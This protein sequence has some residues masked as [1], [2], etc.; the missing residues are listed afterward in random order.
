MRLSEVLEMRPNIWDEENKFP[1]FDEIYRA[2]LQDKIVD[3]YRNYEI[4]QETIGMFCH[5]LNRKMRE[6][7]PYYNQLYKSQIDLDPLQTMSITTESESLA[8]ETTGQESTT[9]NTSATDSKSRSVSSET[10][11]TMLS[12][13]EDYASSAADAI[14]NT[15]VTGNA[16]GNVSGNTNS[17]GTVSSTVTGSQ[18]HAATLLMQ[19]RKSFLNLDMDVIRELESLFMMVWD[20]GDEFNTDSSFG[21]IYYGWPYG[22]F[23]TI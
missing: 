16:A 6:I 4:G 18:G 11:Q 1:I 7:M 21:G 2:T 14:S 15:N 22:W 3:H 17:N 9:T 13:N 20:N 19:Y 5:A 23:G 8:T 12:G 10:P